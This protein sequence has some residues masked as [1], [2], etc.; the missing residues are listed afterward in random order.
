MEYV[1]DNFNNVSSA[2]RRFYNLM[3]ESTTYQNLCKKK[4]RSL[5]TSN[6][7]RS[8]LLKNLQSCSELIQDKLFIEKILFTELLY[9]KRC[10]IPRSLRK[11]LLFDFAEKQSMMFRNQKTF[12]VNNYC[13]YLLYNLD[14]KINWKEIDVSKK[15]NKVEI[16]YKNLE[17]DFLCDIENI[18]SMMKEIIMIKYDEFTLDKIII[19]ESEVIR[20]CVAKYMRKLSKYLQERD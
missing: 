12:E 3:F 15:S 18:R 4:L 16:Y 14:M 11:L 9:L 20:L 1:T 2:S 7:K 13:N 5:I 10:D 6:Q 19:E 17:F 8:N